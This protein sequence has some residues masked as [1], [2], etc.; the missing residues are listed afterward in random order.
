MK[1]YQS[2]KVY[3]L[4]EAVKDQHKN[5]VTKLHPAPQQEIAAN[6]KDSFHWKRVGLH[7]LHSVFN[8]TTSQ[9]LEEKNFF[10]GYLVPLATMHK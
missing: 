2:V 3:S 4:G 7:S 8:K 10:L 6:I 1:N 9:I 5:V